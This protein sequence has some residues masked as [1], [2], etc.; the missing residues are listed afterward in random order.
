MGRSVEELKNSMSYEELLDWVEYTK[1]QPFLDDIVEVQLAKMMY[2]VSSAL[3]GKSKFEDFLM[4]KVS[5][6]PKNKKAST[7]DIL[8]AFNISKKGV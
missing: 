5:S 3:G 7:S 2:I 4:T 6:K 1:H 8:K